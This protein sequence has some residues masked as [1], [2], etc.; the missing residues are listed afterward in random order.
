MA[1]GTKKTFRQDI[2]GAD[3]LGLDPG[4]GTVK[5]FLTSNTQASLEDR[6]AFLQELKSSLCEAYIWTAAQLGMTGESEAE[7]LK[8]GEELAAAIGRAVNA[9]F[10]NRQREYEQ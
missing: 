7:K 6:T 4:R 1:V 3:M 2:I 5:I 10:Q 8:S 9:A